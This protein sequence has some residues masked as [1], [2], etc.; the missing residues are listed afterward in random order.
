MPF[1][2]FYMLDLKSEFQAK[3]YLFWYSIFSKIFI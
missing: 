1:N 3:S 2:D